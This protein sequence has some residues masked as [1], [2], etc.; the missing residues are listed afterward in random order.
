MQKMQAEA[1]GQQPLFEQLDAE[2]REAALVSERMLRVRGEHDAE[3][4]RYRRRAG[5][6]QERWQ[7]VFAQIDLRLSELE[8]LRRQMRS[9]RG[10]YDALMLWAADAKQRQE[11]IQA[12][13]IGNGGALREQLCQEQVRR[14]L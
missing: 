8:H 5:G 10:S 13:P 7:A 14:P 9:Y 6:L 3:L 12:V 1:R 2:L 4:E 11:A